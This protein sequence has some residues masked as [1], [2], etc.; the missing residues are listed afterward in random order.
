PLIR[1]GGDDERAGG[2]CFPPDHAVVE[3]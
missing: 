2:E 1:E 3:E